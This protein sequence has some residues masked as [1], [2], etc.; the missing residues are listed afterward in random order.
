MVPT[1][2]QVVKCYRVI[3]QTEW[4]KT[5][6]PGK[7]TAANAIRGTKQVCR[8]AGVD[9]DAPVTSLTRKKIDDA[10]VTFTNKG[11]SRISA[12]SYVFQLRAV[13]AKWCEPY[14]GDAGW[15]IPKLEFPVFRAR[16]PRYVRPSSEML[17]RV[18]SWY[19][20]LANE[21]WLVA[22][23]MLEFAM[24][25]G[26]ILRLNSTNFVEKG[27]KR[28]L[29]YTPH[30]TALSSG[31]HVCWPVHDEI[32]RKI[33]EYGGLE[34]FGITDEIFEDINRELRSIGFRGH[35]AAYELRKI[36]I[37]HV[38]QK[39]GAEMAVSI[40]GDDIRTIT[41]YYADPSSP[42]IGATRIIDLL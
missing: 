28:Y 38:Y 35:K 14:Y 1:I 18:K 33:E 23:M 42:N 7:E 25:N 32:W 11:L 5:G 31:R 39:Y 36:C 40:S 2:N 8:A 22:T 3:A 6:R 26:D 24:R 34:C 41:K 37:D 27:G 17:S 10:L 16:P 30:K 4:M 19:V 29:S 20:Q 21:H 9:L 13:F 15:E 12:L